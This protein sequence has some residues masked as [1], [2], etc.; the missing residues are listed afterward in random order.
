MLVLLALGRKFL[1]KRMWVTE[2]LNQAS[3]PV[4]LLHQ[5]ILV[6]V[7]YY[8]VQG[9]EGVAWQAFAV[10]SGS[11]VLTVAAYHM[12]RLMPGVRALVGQ[13]GKPHIKGD[14]R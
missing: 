4:Y 1:D 9:V 10:C 5:T 7:A 12:V 6:A 8:T 11:F 3:Y 13:K 14:R 2:Y